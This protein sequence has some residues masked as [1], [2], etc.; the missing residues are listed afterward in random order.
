MNISQYL[1]YIPYRLAWS[2][3]HLFRR[4]KQIHFYCGSQVDYVA[5]KSI[6]KHFPEAEIVAK[7]RKVKKVF[8]EL[9]IRCRTYPTFPDVLIMPRHTARKYPGTHI[10]KIG[11]RHGAYHFK[12]FVSA[13]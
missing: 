12:D 3:L 5:V 6:I 9:G 8:T 1:I 2:A 11:L 10:K 7:N 4:R 13:R